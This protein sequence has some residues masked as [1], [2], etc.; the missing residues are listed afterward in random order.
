[1]VTF[2]VTLQIPAGSF[3]QG[4]KKMSQLL[5]RRETAQADTLQPKGNQ[6]TS[7]HH[8][9]APAFSSLHTR[10]SSELSKG[11]AGREHRDVTETSV[12][13]NTELKGEGC[14]RRSFPHHNQ[15]VISPR[16]Q[17][18]AIVWPSHTVHTSWNAQKKVCKMKYVS[19]WFWTADRIYITNKQKLSG[20]I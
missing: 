18:N 16:G 5:Q 1:M 8:C 20:D 17:V 2:N 4:E 10:W 14:L 15:L 12:K 9:G 3:L 7:Q 19:K 11:S 6:V 13:W